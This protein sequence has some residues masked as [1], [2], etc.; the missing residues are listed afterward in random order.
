MT[1]EQLGTVANILA[2][3]IGDAGKLLAS[4][5]AGAASNEASARQLRS[6]LELATA[7]LDSADIA[8]AARDKAE[9][10]RVA[11]L[12]PDEPTKP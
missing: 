1:I 12:L 4:I 2:P 10:A 8:F 6:V 3:L 11:A 7:R 9:D 5:M